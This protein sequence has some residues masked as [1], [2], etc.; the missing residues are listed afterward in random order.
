MPLYEGGAIA[1]MKAIG[2]SATGAIV[3]LVTVKRQAG[4]KTGLFVFRALFA[5]S[6]GIAISHYVGSAIGE[7]ASLDAVSVDGIKF[8]AGV[9]GM[10]AVRLAYE[11][12]PDILSAFIAR[13]GGAK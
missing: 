5:F 3:S 12:M 2:P 9:F 4:E 8:L 10:N 11:H 6:S 7:Y 1:A 13:L